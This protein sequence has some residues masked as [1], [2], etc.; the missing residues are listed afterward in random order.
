MQ[1]NSGEG[2]SRVDWKRR[3]FLRARSADRRRREEDHRGAGPSP[4][5]AASTPLGFGVTWASGAPT[6]PASCCCPEPGSRRGRPLNSG[7][8]AE[9]LRILRWVRGP[10]GHLW[11]PEGP[12]FREEGEP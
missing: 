7:C 8:A 6:V 12:H 1:R 10:E 11:G 2:A 3:S 4:G 5:G 9:D